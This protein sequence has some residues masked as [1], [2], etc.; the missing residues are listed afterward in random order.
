MS[1]A[2]R[3]PEAAPPDIA[4]DAPAALRAPSLRRRLAC[5]MYEGVLMFGVVVPAGLI[6]SVVTQMR[7]GL[8][9]R[10][11]LIAFLFFVLG[12]YFV[13]FWS[14]GQ[15]L[16][17]KT[18]R[19]RVV[20]RYGRR[21][22][23]GRAVIRYGFCYIWLLPPLAAFSTRQVAA[24]PVFVLLLGWVAFW[25]LLSRLHPERQFWHDALAG[26]RLV[27]APAR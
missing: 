13:W 5:W 15:T 16:A 6:F 27:S 12:L 11:G 10:Q 14:R 7:H 17:M 21:L 3:G 23:L 18:W 20:D 26:T 8:A 1:S 19:I 9:H 22:T 24:G 25:A 2:S 4:G